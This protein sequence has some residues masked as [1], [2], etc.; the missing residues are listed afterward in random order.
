[1]NWLLGHTF[2]VTQW[3][4]VSRV[5]YSIDSTFISLC[6]S[7][8]NDML[9]SVY[10]VYYPVYSKECSLQP[11]WVRYNQ[12]S[13]RFHFVSSMVC[14]VVS[15]IHHW[16]FCS[17]SITSCVNVQLSH[18]SFRP[19]TTVGQESPLS[20]DNC[21][22]LLTIYSA[23]PLSYAGLWPGGDIKAELCSYLRPPGGW[24]DSEDQSHP[25]FYS[26]KTWNFPEYL[27]IIIYNRVSYISNV[28]KNLH[29]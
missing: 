28:C 3:L 20:C 12:Y 9:V 11:E 7:F 8:K 22:A 17:V 29:S 21:P 6:N 24:T 18:K 27:T 23:P 4:S 15:S 16:T 25:W 1:M 10:Q 5:S 14:F 19:C 13:I 2:S 26:G